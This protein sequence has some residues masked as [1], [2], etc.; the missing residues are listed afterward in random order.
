MKKLILALCVVLLLAFNAWAVDVR[1]ENRSGEKIVYR[2][3]QIDHEF[4][5]LIGPFM[6]A[7]GEL[8]SSHEP[9]NYV[10]LNNRSGRIHAIY[11]EYVK[12]GIS[13]Y[14][15]FKGDV[16]KFLVVVPKVEGR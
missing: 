11:I 5:Q 4:P 12:S 13:F 15:A 2:I 1:V 16:E 8:P 7:M 6:Y 10:E 3:S 9:N 14:T